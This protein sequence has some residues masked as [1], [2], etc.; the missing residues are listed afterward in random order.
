MRTRGQWFPLPISSPASYRPVRSGEFPHQHPAT[1]AGSGAASS[2]GLPSHGDP[3]PACSPHRPPGLPLLR[4]AHRH[5]P[6]VDLGDSHT[7]RRPAP[8]CGPFSPME[9]RYASDRCHVPV[10]SPARGGREA[11]QALSFPLGFMGIPM[12][13]TSPL[14]PKAEMR[15]TSGA[16]PWRRCSSGS[17]RRPSTTTPRR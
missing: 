14:R 15:W 4:R 12:L 6:S 10:C 13:P 11:P 7:D 17:G 3:L 9:A 8:G 2:Q 16:R 5:V 1:G